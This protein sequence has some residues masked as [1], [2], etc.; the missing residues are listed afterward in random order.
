MAGEYRSAGTRHHARSIGADFKSWLP[1]FPLSVC[2]SQF[3]HVSTDGKNNSTSS[4]Y[5]FACLPKGGSS[6]RLDAGANPKKL[7]PD[8]DLGEGIGMLG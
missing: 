8:P 6:P 1:L 7:D 5:C 2:G 4:N 3:F